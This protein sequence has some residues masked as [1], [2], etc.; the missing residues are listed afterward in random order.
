MSLSKNETILSGGEVVPQS[1]IEKILVGE[2]I[3]PQSRIEAL[4]KEKLCGG[5][6]SAPA[7]GGVTTL[8]I[9]VTAVNRETMEAT[10]TADKTPAEMEQALISGPIWCVVTVAAGIFGERAVSVGVPPTWQG[11]G[12]VAFGRVIKPAHNG[13]GTNEIGYAVKGST[14][15]VVD[16]TRIV[17]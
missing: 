14:E 10:F 2:D 7:A 11:A 8:H 13:D 5:G 12:V 9:N 6:G 16:M 4:L 1:R 3:E 15:W 17:S